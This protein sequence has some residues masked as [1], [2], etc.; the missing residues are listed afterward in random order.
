MRRS[1]FPLLAWLLAALLL[2]SAG[3]RALAGGIASLE[4]IT[5]GGR[6]QTISLRGGNRANPVLLFLHGGP[7]FPGMLFERANADLERDFTVVHWDQRGAGKSYFPDLP[8]E[9]MNVEQF[10][11]DALELTDEL[12]RRFGQRKIYLVGHSWG[13]LVGALVVRSAPERFVAY[14]S[15]SQLVDINASEREL[16]RGA[17]AAAQAHGAAGAERELGALGPPPYPEVGDRRLARVKKRLHQLGP[18]VPARITPGRFLALA[19]GSPDYHWWEFP[20][21]LRGYRFSNET[22]KAGIYRRD[23][24]REAPRLDAPVYFF[25]GRHDTVLTAAVAGRYFRRLQAPRGKQLVT[26][27]NSDH[28]PHL[29]EPGR[30]AGCARRPGPRRVRA[31][32]PT[33]RRAG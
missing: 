17:V 8:A 21:V 24:R 27:E 20:R 32:L 10:V 16:Y 4:E 13:S 5:L 29:E 19:F 14:V 15:I 28:W 25:L 30:C 11:R 18:P 22:L 6:R 1:I 33:R 9:T 23:L 31:G 3:P 26:F 2:G 7:G 12:R